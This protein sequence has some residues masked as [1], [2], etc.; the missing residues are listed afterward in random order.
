MGLEFE[1]DASK[2]K[3]NSAK[4]RV[5]FEEIIGVLVG[6]ASRMVVSAPS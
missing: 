6:N 5:S 4:H 1:L 3:L 2:A